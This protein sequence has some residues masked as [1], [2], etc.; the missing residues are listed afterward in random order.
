MYRSKGGGSLLREYILLTGSEAVSRGLVDSIRTLAAS[1]P[2]FKKSVPLNKDDESRVN[3]I[4]KELIKLG[5]EVCLSVCLVLLSHLFACVGMSG[6][7]RLQCFLCMFCQ[8]AA[9]TCCVEFGMFVCPL[10]VCPL[11]F[12]LLLAS[13]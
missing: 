8:P 7:H 1:C 3:A 13:L 6:Q 2:G 11:H 10:Y 5:S 12:F 9:S 4:E